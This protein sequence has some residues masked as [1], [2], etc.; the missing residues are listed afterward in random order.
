MEVLHHESSN[1]LE[2]I[3]V[4]LILA[5]CILMIVEMSGNSTIFFQTISNFLSFSS[6]STAPASITPHEVIATTTSMDTST[7]MV[8]NGIMS[9]SLT[10]VTSE[11]VNDISHDATTRK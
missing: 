6:S 2:W 9:P 4:V 8:S 3:I 1:N 11:N 5:E 7:T 10:D